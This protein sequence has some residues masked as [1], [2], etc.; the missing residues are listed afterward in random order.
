MQD[1]FV[2]EVHAHSSNVAMAYTRKEMREE[3]K[4]YIDVAGDVNI[5]LNLSDIHS[6]NGRPDVLREWSEVAQELADKN[7]S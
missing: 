5:D 7:L 1:K 4:H 6:I 2:L 3:L